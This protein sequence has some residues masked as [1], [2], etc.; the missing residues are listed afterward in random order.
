[1]KRSGLSF[2]VISFACLF[3]L[4]AFAC[5]FN[6]DCAIGST[7]EKAPGALSGACIGGRNP[8]NSDDRNPVQFMRDMSG[9]I[10]NT[11]SYDLDCGI[12]NRCLKDGGALKGIC[13]S[14]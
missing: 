14:R 10:G 1:M 9:K 6:T 3:A 7:C 13:A 12:G 8:G 2:T 4:D 5:Q 11:C